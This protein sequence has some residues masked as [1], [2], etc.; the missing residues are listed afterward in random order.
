VIGVFRGFS[1]SISSLH[2]SVFHKEFCLMTKVRIAGGSL[3]SLALVV[4]LTLAGENIK[5][6][7][8][9]GKQVPGPFHPLNVTG[10]SAGEKACLYC[11]NGSSPVAMIFAREI[12]NNLIALI[13]KID[14]C[15]A[16]NKDNKMGSFVV[17]L[18]DAEDLSNQLKALAEKEGIKSTVLAID[19]PAG[20]QDYKIARDA[21]V[22]VILYTDHTVKAN[23]AFARGQLNEANIAQIVGDVA[24]ILRD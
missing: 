21:D 7:P 12:S 13:K 19:N 24:K 14:E 11:K 22:T 15:T 20:P 1:L 17:F 9:V 23:H 6:G 10:E 2:V 5:S 18:N 8:P 3:L 4:G 16:K